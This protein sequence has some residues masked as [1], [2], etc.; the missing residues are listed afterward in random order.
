M[1][2]DTSDSTRR[3]SLLRHLFITNHLPDQDFW[4][5]HFYEPFQDEIFQE[6]SVSGFVFNEVRENFLLSHLHDGDEEA[7]MVKENVRV[8]LVH[9][10]H[11]GA[12]DERTTMDSFGGVA[13]L[14]FL[15]MFGMDGLFFLLE[16]F[17]F[18]FFEIFETEYEGFEGFLL[19]FLE[20]EILDG[21]I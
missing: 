8:T 14:D 21:G 11:S 1:H 2:S 16:D 3:W 17:G 5:E 7:K 15:L 18:L 13:F 6:L 4:L 9:F 19:G 12:I 20:Y 10:F